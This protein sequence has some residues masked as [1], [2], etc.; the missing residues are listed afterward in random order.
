[1]MDLIVEEIGGNAKNYYI[2]EEEIEKVKLE[3]VRNLSKLKGYS[4]V[5]LVPD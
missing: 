3:D 4:F 2:Y 5:A 1:M